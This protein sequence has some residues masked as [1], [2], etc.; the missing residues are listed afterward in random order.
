MTQPTW[1]LPKDL[2]SA[3]VQ[4]MRPQGAIGNEG[5]G[6]WFGTAD[7]DEVSVTH[8]VAVHGRGFASAPLQLRLSWRAMSTLTNLADKLGVYLVGQIHSHPGQMLDLS[9]VDREFGIR[10][11][12]YLSFV[13]PYYAQRDITAVDEC[14]VHVFDA[15]HYRRLDRREAAARIKISNSVFERLLVEVP[16]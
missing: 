5:L 13:C 9:E 10:C 12:G 7:D 14:G 1:T 6:L 11:Q 3:S 4:V 2:L 15:G 8:L 16:A